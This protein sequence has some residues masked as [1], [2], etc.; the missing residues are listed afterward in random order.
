MLLYQMITWHVNLYLVLAALA[1]IGVPGAIGL[2][3]LARG[4]NDS[5]NSPEK[6]SSDQLP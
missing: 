6:Q 5:D 2:A 3:T 4:R 1:I